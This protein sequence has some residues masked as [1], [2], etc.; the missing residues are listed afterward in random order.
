MAVSIRMEHVLFGSEKFLEELRQYLFFF[1]QDPTSTTVLLVGT[2]GLGKTFAIEKVVKKENLQHKIISATHIFN[3]YVGESEKRFQA[4]FDEAYET[5]TETGRPYILV[6]D[7]VETLMSERDDGGQSESSGRIKEI[8]LQNVSGMASR[9]GVIIIGIT[10]L[11]WKLDKA[12]VDRCED[13]FKLDLPT[14]P[15]RKKFFYKFVKEKEINC[16]T[17]T[18]GQFELLKTE[19]FSFRN[20]KALIKK[21]EKIG[22]NKRAFSATHF[23]T[24]QGIDGGIRYIGCD[25]PHMSCGGEAMDIKDISDP[26]N[27]LVKSDI[28]FED[29]MFARKSIQ[30]STTKEEVKKVD[31]WYLYRTKKEENITPDITENNLKASK[32]VSCA[33]FFLFFCSLFVILT[34]VCVNFIFPV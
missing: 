24:T 26:F 21:A 15:E 8:F 31:D 17:L 20:L 3:K 27:C 29:F 16:Q 22:P 9:P 7:E 19:M 25:C 1:L 28:T 10:N 6:F 34:F 2:P 30:A 23:K 33:V 12:F 32:S 13:I 11:P 4:G 14:L 5:F 18:D